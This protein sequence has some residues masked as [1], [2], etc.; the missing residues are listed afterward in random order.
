MELM[1]KNNMV[2]CIDYREITE[3]PAIYTRYL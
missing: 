1:K 2:I 3:F